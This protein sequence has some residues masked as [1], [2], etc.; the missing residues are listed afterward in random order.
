MYGRLQALDSYNELIII[1]RTDPNYFSITKHT[2]NGYTRN[3]YPLKDPRGKIPRNK[4]PK[5]ITVSDYQLYKYMV[6]QSPRT[7][8]QGNDNH[9]NYGKK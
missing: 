3:E 9:T 5:I 8:I 7:I 4:L 6:C 2:E 1:E